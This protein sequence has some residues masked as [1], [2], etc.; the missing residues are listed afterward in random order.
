MEIC[1]VKTL[2]DKKRYS[3]I[4]CKGSHFFYNCKENDYLFLFCFCLF[5]SLA[6]LGH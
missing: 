5:T 2:H 6:V 4:E 3:E 1:D